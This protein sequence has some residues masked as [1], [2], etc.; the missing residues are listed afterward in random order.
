MFLFR[1]GAVVNSGDRIFTMKLLA[2]AALVG[3]AAAAPC[4]P[5]PPV[6]PWHMRRG[7]LVCKEIVYAVAAPA[8]PGPDGVRTF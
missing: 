1:V 3:T 5:A 7:V 2:A 4:A 6:R 8:G